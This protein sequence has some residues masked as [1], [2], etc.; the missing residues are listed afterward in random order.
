MNFEAILRD[1]RY[2]DWL[3]V[4]AMD[5]GGRQYLQVR[6]K[7]PDTM[8]PDDAIEQRGRKWFLSEH[9]T[10]SEVVQTALCAVLACVEHEARE[11]F[12]YIGKP[13]FGP[14]FDVDALWGICDRLDQRE[15]L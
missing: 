10:K 12:R 8:A 4:V 2:R 15:R 5:G 3:F 9:M 14:H 1:V 6:F 13:I 7:A 11:E